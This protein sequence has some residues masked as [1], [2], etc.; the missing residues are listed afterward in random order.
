MRQML[1]SSVAARESSSLKTLSTDHW[2]LERTASHNFLPGCLSCLKQPTSSWESRWSVAY[3]HS[4]LLS[5]VFTFSL[6]YSLLLTWRIHFI[7][8]NLPC[9]QYSSLARL[10]SICVSLQT[11]DVINQLKAFDNPYYLWC[12]QIETRSSFWRRLGQ[13]NQPI[14]AYPFCR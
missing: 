13:W 8:M 10:R 7:V 14:P 5:S 11:F 2:S 1:I 12:L 9:F 4:V 6:L 3:R